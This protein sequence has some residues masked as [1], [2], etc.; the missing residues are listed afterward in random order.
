M[1]LR[2]RLVLLLMLP[3]LLVI[4]AY[5]VLRVQQE[6]RARVEDEQA[7]AE[8]M[9]R[10]IQI[11]VESALAV[12]G[13][14]QA[15]L[16][17]LLNDLTAGQKAIDGIRLFNRDGHVVAV[18]TAQASAHPAAGSEVVTRVID[19]GRGELVETHGRAGNWWVY[20]LPVHYATTTGRI[21]SSATRHAL[22]IAF[23][24]PDTQKM[25]R[26]AIRD[27]LVRVGSLTAALALLIAFVLQREILHPLA[28]LAHSIRAL[29]EGRR[30]PPLPVKRHDELG[31]VAEAFNR[32][33]EQLEEARQRVAAEGEYALDLEQ[34]LRRSETLAVAG[35][36]ASGIAHEVGTPLNIISGRA[37]MV[38]RSLP[39]EHPGRQDL[40]RIIHQIDRVSNIVRSLL[41]TVRLGKLEIQRVSLEALIG[42]L[43]PLLEHV[44]RRR[45]ISI[46]TSIP[47]D[48][49]DVAGDPGRLQQV[50]INLLMNAVE[51]IASEGVISIKAWPASNDGRPGVTVEVT[52]TGLGI[53]REALE[54]IFEPFYTTKPVGEG[55]G[56]GL[57]ISRDIIRDHGGTIGARS[58][59]AEG[60]AF[61]VWLPEYENG[62]AA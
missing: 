60:S 26:Q 7:R 42:R 25:A 10:T 61:V 51:A 20:V 34:Q 37:E 48:L 32:M 11:A 27:V 39:P 6:S 13:R 31:E 55:T 58:L 45:G 18:S 22:E 49:R 2:P 8:S 4:G 23:V 15:E 54:Q 59:P 38:L 44:V 14:P 5:S 24:A 30:G 62:T 12:R 21:S 3:L 52:D 17:D 47:G 53:P 1:T 40:E 28:S 43:L 19:T 29:G 16:V 56:L 57:A 50:F 33:T 9:V 41:D 35:K 46:T 36:L